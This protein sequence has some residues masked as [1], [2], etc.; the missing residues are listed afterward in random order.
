MIHGKNSYDTVVH[1]VGHKHSLS[2]IHVI[3]S[4]VVS[5]ECILLPK[6]TIPIG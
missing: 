1:S 5:A 4:E 2:S 6:N 3:P